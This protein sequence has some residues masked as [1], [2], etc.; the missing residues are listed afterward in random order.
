MISLRPFAYILCGIV[1]TLDKMI[2]KLHEVRIW[3]VLKIPV[4]LILYIPFFVLGILMI[5]ISY[6]LGYDLLSE[7]ET[8]TDS[9]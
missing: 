3:N 8:S 7:D 9:L 4:Y 2:R 6:I 1:L 5:V